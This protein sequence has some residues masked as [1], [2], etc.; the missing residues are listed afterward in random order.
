MSWKCV[1]EL[2][3]NNC[4]PWKEENRG[5]RIFIPANGPL[6]NAFNN[7]MALSDASIYCNLSHTILGARICCG[8]SV[9]DGHHKE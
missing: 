5:S 4:M 3:G 7:S 8:K 6:E 1:S 9:H 2:F